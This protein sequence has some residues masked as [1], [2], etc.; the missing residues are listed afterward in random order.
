MFQVRVERQVLGGN[1]RSAPVLP[2]LE[3]MDWAFCNWRRTAPPRP[4]RPKQGCPIRHL[5]LS[6]MRGTLCV[7]EELVAV[8]A[9]V[10]MVSWRQGV[11]VKTG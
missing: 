3:H 11:F 7:S 5:V 6:S 4:Y 8:T 9:V 1:T 10:S 2:Y